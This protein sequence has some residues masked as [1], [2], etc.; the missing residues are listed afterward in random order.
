MS[1]V[2]HQLGLA[3]EN[4]GTYLG[5]GEWAT[6]ADAGTIESVNPTTGELLGHVHAT[7]PE[8]F[9][10]ASCRERVLTGV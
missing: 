9:G 3:V 8:Q 7:T 2:L 5:G 10:R 6:G 1:E 4:S